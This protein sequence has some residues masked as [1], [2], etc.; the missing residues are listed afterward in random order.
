MKSDI[1][2]FG[3]KLSLRD[4]EVRQSTAKAHP[5]SG[6]SNPASSP[7]IGYKLPFSIGSRPF[8]THEGQHSEQMRHHNGEGDGRLFIGS[9]LLT[10]ETAPSSTFCRLCPQY[11]KKI[12]YSRACWHLLHQGWNCG[13]PPFLQ[14]IRFKLF[15]HGERPVRTQR[16]TVLGTPTRTKFPTLVASFLRQ[17]SS[18]LSKRIAYNDP[19]RENTCFGW[20]KKA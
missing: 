18:T 9:S 20:R 5:V 4:A 11:G 6:H 15:H 2:R 12:I 13:Y 14:I 19:T 7:Q 16:T 1:S 8:V 10:R 3:E 17:L